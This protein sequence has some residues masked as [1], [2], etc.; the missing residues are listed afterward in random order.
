MKRLIVGL[1]AISISFASASV[2][3]DK[4]T[5]R[6]FQAADIQ[7]AEIDPVNQPGVLSSAEGAV[8]LK[9]AK[10]RVDGRVMARVDHANRPYSIWWVI[11][12]NPE[13]C[14]AGVPP[15]SCGFDDLFI[16]AVE[17]AVF[18]ASGAISA[19]TGGGGGVI[20]VDLS[21]IAGEGAG[22][23]S[24]VAF[25]GLPFCLEEFRKKNG[26]CAEIHVDI[27]AHVIEDANNI[28]WVQELT[29]PENPQAFA[30]FPPVA[31]CKRK[32]HK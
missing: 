13:E 1:V 16:P 26:L 20:N 10:D 25:C 30:V 27:N 2:L 23:G 28:D 17:A 18:N 14:A 9:R 11:F 22:N 21:V 4:K 31:K 24:Q 3:A 8:W 7:A 15:T 12:N 6:V 29:Y 32:R 5:A 19:A